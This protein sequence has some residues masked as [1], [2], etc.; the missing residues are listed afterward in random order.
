MT[1]ST[2]TDIDQLPTIADHLPTGLWEAD[3]VAASERLF[4]AQVELLRDGDGGVIALRFKDI[5]SLSEN[6][7]V[8]SAPVEFLTG[9][10]AE[11][12]RRAGQAPTPVMA[13]NPFAVFLRNQIF[14]T[15]PPVHNNVRR[16][17]ARHLMPRAV[18]QFLP[19][20]ERIASE[21][22]DAARRDGQCDFT[23]DIASRYVT[24]FWTDQLGIPDDESGLIQQLMAEMNRMF[25]F[26]P[27]T[28]D[29]QRVQSACAS[30]MEVVG[31][32][33]SR[34]WRGGDNALLSALAADL[35]AADEPAGPE[36]LGK[37]VASNFFDGFHTV[38]VALSNVFYYLLANPESHR[39]VRSDAAL[40]PQAFRE[41]IRLGA[42]LMM[43]T[44]VTLDAVEYNGL[45][46]PK[47]TPITMIW[48]AGNRDPRAFD[49]P[50][51]YRLMRPTHPTTTFGGGAHICPGRNAARLLSE[52]ALRVLTSSEVHIELAETTHR[53]IPGSAIRHLDAMP[54]TIARGGPA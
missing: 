45:R 9:R 26:A 39:R 53:W 44:R 37:L 8:G 15:N 41:G 20:A 52:V 49:E 5:R 47:N 29:S 28:E 33:V 42:P 11:R 18:H 24:R 1:V 19:A 2:T 23:R 13:D 27:T 38:G 30:Y 17:V 54:V 4:D 40:V 32:A 51:A 35:A 43:T 25:L 36:D 48:A 3:V 21:V 16:I 7:L 14:T 34:A 22:V 50:A 12:L 46:V 10:A 31:D 6:P